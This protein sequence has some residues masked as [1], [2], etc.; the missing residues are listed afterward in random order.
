MF[1]KCSQI[2]LRFKHNGLPGFDIT[3]NSEE[4]V[5][6]LDEVGYYLI[7]EYPDMISEVKIQKKVVKGEK[8]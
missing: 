7:G 4:P 3:F 8:R 6:V 5:P 2:G 1:I